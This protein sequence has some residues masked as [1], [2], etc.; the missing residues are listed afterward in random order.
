M[1]IHSQR[2]SNTLVQGSSFNG[3]NLAQS[4]NLQGMSI[5]NAYFRLVPPIYKNSGSGQN[6]NQSVLMNESGG[7]PLL[8]PIGA[9]ILAVIISTNEAITSNSGNISSYIG[10][11]VNPRYNHQTNTWEPRDGLG[12]GISIINFSLNQLHTGTSS[13]PFSNAINAFPSLNAYMGGGYQTIKPQDAIC[14]VKLLITNPT[15]AQ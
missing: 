10:Y 5:V 2:N 8:L 3:G 12:P 11:A 7:N 6:A 4:F 1:I 13:T 9:C 15:L 14:K